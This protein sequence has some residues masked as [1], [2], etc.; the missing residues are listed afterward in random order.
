VLDLTSSPRTA[1]L[2]YW[3]GQYVAIDDEESGWRGEH[4]RRGDL[5]RGGNGEAHRLIAGQMMK[6]TLRILPP[7]VRN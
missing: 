3:Q 4:S 2:A 1:A 6:P 5:E 7:H